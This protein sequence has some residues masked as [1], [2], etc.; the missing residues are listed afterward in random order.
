[1]AKKKIKTVDVSPDVV[2][3]LYFAVQDYVCSRGGN[4]LVAGGVQVIQW[5]YQ[6]DT[7]FSIVVKCTGKKPDFAK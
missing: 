7:Q 3:R 6:P 5:P 1:M 4:V 2:E